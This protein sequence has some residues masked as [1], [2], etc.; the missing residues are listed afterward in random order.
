MLDADKMDW[1]KDSFRV[2]AD[3]VREQDFVSLVVF[4]TSAKV[5]IPS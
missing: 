4:D 2:F 5:L 1:V 3:Q